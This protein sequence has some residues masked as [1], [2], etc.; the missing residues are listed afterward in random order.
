MSTT[1]VV[2]VLLAALICALILGEKF[3]KRRVP[4]VILVASGAAALKFAS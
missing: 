2:A 3:G 4:A 1:V